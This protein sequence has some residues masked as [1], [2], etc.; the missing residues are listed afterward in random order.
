MLKYNKEREQISFNL[1]LAADKPTW[2]CNCVFLVILITNF[3]DI[4]QRQ[5]VLQLQAEDDEAD[6]QT[7]AVPGPVG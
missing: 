2:H 4:G 3:D 7:Q 6:T 1:A 5:R